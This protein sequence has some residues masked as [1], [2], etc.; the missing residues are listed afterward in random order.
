MSKKHLHPILRAALNLWSVE[1]DG[2]FVLSD[3]VN[4]ASFALRR[5]LLEGVQS[6]ENLA[7]LK[8]SLWAYRDALIAMGIDLGALP[9]PPGVSLP[10]KVDSSA[11]ACVFGTG[12]YNGHSLAEVATRDRAYLERVARKW[13]G[14]KRVARGALEVLLGFPVQTWPDEWRRVVPKQRYA[15]IRREGDHLFVT[16]SRNEDLWNFCRGLWGAIYNKEKRGWLV[17]AEHAA[18]L[19]E[20]EQLLAC[21]EDVLL[22]TREEFKDKVAMQEALRLQLQRQGW[23]TARQILDARCPRY[24]VRS[25]KKKGKVA[26]FYPYNEELDAQLSTLV[27]ARWDKTI[28]ARVFDEVDVVIVYRLLKG[29]G[30]V[31]EACVAKAV[32]EELQRQKK[33]AVEAQKWHHPLK[34]ANDANLKYVGNNGITLF[35]YQRADVAYALD[36]LRKHGGVGLFLD[37]GLG[38]TVQGT[39]I[40]D[41]LRQERDRL[42][43]LIF[44]PR[45]AF[46]AWRR[47]MSGMLGA[48]F[49]YARTKGGKWGR[50]AMAQLMSEVDRGLVGVIV[51]GSKEARDEVLNMPVD[52]VVINYDSARLTE[53]ALVSWVRQGGPILVICD[54]SHRFKDPNTKTTKTILKVVQL[55]QAQV[56]NGGG[57]LA[58]SGSPMPKG[59]WE[60][61]TQAAFIDGGIQ[62]C[63]FGPSYRAFVDRFFYIDR[64]PE[65]KW[66]RPKKFKSSALRKEFMNH[67]GVFTVRRTKEEELD[68]PPKTYHLIEATFEGGIEQKLYKFLL[69]LKKN[70][71][72]EMS[73]ADVSNID[74]ALLFLRMRQLISH[75]NNLVASYQRALAS[76]AEAE[77]IKLEALRKGEKPRSVK[78]ENEDV[79]AIPEDMIQ[80]LASFLKDGGMPV[81]LSLL[82]DHVDDIMADPEEKLIIGCDFQETERAIVEALAPY[83]P[84]WFSS[85]LNDEERLEAEEAFQKD[86]SRRILVANSATICEG[87]TLTAARHM[88]LYDPATSYSTRTWLQVQ[89]RIYRPGQTRNVIISHLVLANS[90][91]V[92]GLSRVISEAKEASRLLRDAVSS[93][94]ASLSDMVMKGNVFRNKTSVLNLLDAL[95]GGD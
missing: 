65:G 55:E 26:V 66:F 22:S 38:K 44:C 56:E 82:V 32:E 41:I 31:F 53:E 12:I 21:N 15:T 63:R 24:V 95:S 93:L 43:V 74:P 25:R 90:I 52:I 81:K 8:N 17:P 57:R 34:R 14:D 35:R 29:Q 28:G 54:E 9:E 5:V 51:S 16:F 50:Q 83:N 39:A 42:R 89:D 91:D 47:E 75:P 87:L 40:Y 45:S 86:V 37:M 2:L 59:P 30:F 19:A 20:N 88:I 11:E 67:A 68:L 85:S 7:S 33:A 60:F 61:Y 36:C 73:D 92:Y 76:K 46:S 72:N 6:P 3:D 78:I 69:A 58:L 27:Q 94:P 77:R 18:T 48:E 71:I 62:K 23:G 64:G 1:K 49:F 13:P 84:I 10:L 70:E 4:D 80:E 79:L